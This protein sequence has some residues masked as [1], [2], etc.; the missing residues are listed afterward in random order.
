MRNAIGQDA[1]WVRINLTPK[2]REL[3]QIITGEP[4][5]ALEM[6]LPVLR[7]HLRVRMGKLPQPCVFLM[8]PDRALGDRGGATS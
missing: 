5:G 3:L 2:Q 4:A 8:C 6:P 7:T 1:V